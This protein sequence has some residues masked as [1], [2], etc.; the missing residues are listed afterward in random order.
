MKPSLQLFTSQDALSRLSRL[1]LSILALLIPIW[2]LPFTQNILAYQKQTL[3]V[4]FVFLGLIAW[5]AKAMNQGEFTFRLSWLH[6]PVGVLIGIVGVSA[7]FSKWPYASFWGFPLDISESFLTVLSFGLLYLLISNTIE[8]TRHLVKFLFLVILSGVLAGIVAILQLKGIFLPF[9]FAKSAAFN[10]IGSPNS[11]AI[12]ASILLPLALVL[13][14]VSRL[15]LR[16]LLWIIVLILFIVIAFINFSVAWIT[17]TGGLIVLLVFGML[18][19]RKRTEFGWISFPMAFVVLSLFFLVFQ[20]SVPGAPEVP[21]EVSPSQGATFEIVREVISQRPIVGSGPGTFVFDYTSFHSPTLNQTIFWGTRFATGSSEVLDWLATKGILGILSLLALLGAGLVVSVKHLLRFGAEEKDAT[22]QEQ[23]F[24]WMIG[25]GLLA[26]FASIVISQFLYPSNFVLWFLFWVLL[27]GLVVV[28]SKTTK[29]YSVSPPSLLAPALSFVFLLVLIFGLGL[30]FIGG[31]KYAGEVQYLRGA[32]ASAQGDLDG[33]IT[34]TLSAVRLNGS[35]DIYWR[36][37]SQLYL[38]KVNELGIREGLTDE[39]RQQLQVVA[40]SNSI[41]SAQRAVQIA[42]ANVA[43][44]NVQGFIYRNFIGLEGAETFAIASYEKVSEME[45]A[46]PFSFTELGRVYIMQA[47]RLAEQQEFAAQKEEALQKA[48]DSLQKA[49]EMKADY[50]PAHYLI[51]VVYEAR[52]ESDEAIAKLEETKQVAPN[53]V[54]LAFQLGVIY[55]Q[56]DQLTKAQAELERAKRIDPNYA[57]ARYLLGLVYDE[58]GE[59]AKAIAEFEAIA[60][61]NP[62]NTQ[63]QQILSNLRAGAPALQGIQSEEPPIPIEETPPEIEEE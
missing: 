4:V 6:V 61:L 10:T 53:D 29:Q 30:F 46:S 18:N 11:V 38:A 54:G 22:L 43:N 31:Q 5:L 9:A 32:L 20:I 41:S 60:V 40:A 1:S 7:I 59:T 45:P 19:M 58:K 50:A 24:S 52:G 55:R 27:G 17:L 39:E 13:A 35:V 57:N 36:D 42:P 14:F 25:L 56:R 15:L 26:S 8:D 33:A 49:I 23:N 63:I 28:T 3:L 16:W 2:V 47:Q 21:V 48:L 51:A 34:K 44:W 37:L 62:D 12:V